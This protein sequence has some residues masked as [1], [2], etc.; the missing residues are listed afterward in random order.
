MDDLAIVKLIFSAI[1]IVM[2]AVNV[3]AMSME[4]LFKIPAPVTSD[5][6]FT[7]T[8]FDAYCGF[9]TFYCWVWLKEKSAALRVLWFVLIML[10][11]NIAMSTYMLI[12]L[13]RL[14]KDASLKDLLIPDSRF[15]RDER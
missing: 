9:L 13:F 4:S 12:A 7:A 3:R 15:K 5:P 10:F 1:L 2:L 11:G 14:A 8:L 6:W